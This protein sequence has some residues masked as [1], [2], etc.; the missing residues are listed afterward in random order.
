MSSSMRSTPLPGCSGYLPH[1]RMAGSLE[2]R[3]LR[4]AVP[5]GKRDSEAEE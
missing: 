5:A 1:V 3:F 4:M 2:V